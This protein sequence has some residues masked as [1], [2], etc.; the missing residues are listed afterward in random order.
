MINQNEILFVSCYKSQGLIKNG[1]IQW[2]KL[3]KETHYLLIYSFYVLNFWQVKFKSILLV[4]RNYWGVKIGRFGVKIPF[5]TFADN[6]LLFAKDSNQSCTIIKSI[7]DK[8]YSMYGQLVNF[9]KSSFQCMKDVMPEDITVFQSILQKNS[10]FLLASYLSF[11]IIDFRVS[12]HT[13]Q[14]VI[15]SSQSQLAKGKAN[16]LSQAGRAVL[17]QANLATK[18]DF[19]M[20]SFL[21][22]A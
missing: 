5:L 14:K 8:Y 1:F 6:T 21:L 4:E 16:T 18:A 15:Q 9:H 2:I 12:K 22:P 13:F 20:Q 3:D 11:P 19:Q 17:V 7:L 10:S